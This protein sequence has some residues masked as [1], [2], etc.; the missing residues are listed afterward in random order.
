MTGQ[1]QMH[2]TKCTFTSPDHY[3]YE[4]TRIYTA[5]PPFTNKQFTVRGGVTCTT[6]HIM[7]ENN[8]LTNLTNEK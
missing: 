8:A 4:H 5:I 3:E 7:F 2:K 1:K 6:C